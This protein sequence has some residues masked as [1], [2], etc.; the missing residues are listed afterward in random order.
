MCGLIA[1]EQTLSITRHL[2]FTVRTGFEFSQIFN[3]HFFASGI[4]GYLLN[5]KTTCIFDNFS[6]MNINTEINCCLKVN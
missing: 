6:F 2:T 3:L 4:F 1:V 5:E